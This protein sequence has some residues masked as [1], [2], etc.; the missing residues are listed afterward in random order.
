M[1]NAR[2]PS[3]NIDLVEFGTKP[4]WNSAL[5]QVWT[6][7]RRL[8]WCWMF[9]N[10]DPHCT[11][12][13]KIKRIIFLYFLTLLTLFNC[14]GLNWDKENNYLYVNFLSSAV[15][16]TAPSPGSPEDRGPRTEKDRGQ[17]GQKT[18]KETQRTQ[19]ST[20]RDF[21]ASMDQAYFSTTNFIWLFNVT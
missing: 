9:V 21:A 8:W 12:S 20:W 17:K 5:W 13:I 2:T 15:Q 10:G 18:E 14:T 7:H 1:E 11:K 3:M 6:R 4:Y 19:I 16:T